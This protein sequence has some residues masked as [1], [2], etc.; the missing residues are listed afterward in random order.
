[1]TVLKS[2]AHIQKLKLAMF[3]HRENHELYDKKYSSVLA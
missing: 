1:L 3:T 2:K